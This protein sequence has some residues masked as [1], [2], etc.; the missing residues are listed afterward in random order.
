M[1]LLFVAFLL[2]LYFDYSNAGSFRMP[3]EVLERPS[4]T[5]FAPGDS[6]GVR[7]RNF[8]DIEYYGTTVIGSNSQQFRIVFDTGLFSFLIISLF[9]VLMEF[10]FR[11]H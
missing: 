1:L 11:K 10:N 5:S 2:S 4:N 7:L 3:L 9:I 8:G 6:Y